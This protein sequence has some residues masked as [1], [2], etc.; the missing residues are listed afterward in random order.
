MDGPA[1]VVFARWPEG[2]GFPESFF[3]DGLPDGR[4]EL[5]VGHRVGA[6]QQGQEQL[7][8]VYKEAVVAQQADGDGTP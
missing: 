7:P 6:Q 8:G 5:A 1:D 4:R 2:P 3:G